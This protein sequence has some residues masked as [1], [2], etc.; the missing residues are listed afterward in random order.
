MAGTT[1]TMDELDTKILEVILRDGGPSNARIADD[2]GVSESTV[3]RRR[4]RLARELFG[5]PESLPT[6]ATEDQSAHDLNR[7]P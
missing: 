6:K 5:E 3:R 4:N 7:S 1:M 2:L